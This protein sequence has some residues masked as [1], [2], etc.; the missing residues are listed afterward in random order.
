[1]AAERRLRVWFPAPISGRYASS[2]GSSYSLRKYLNSFP[3]LRV[4]RP[5]LW[6]GVAYTRNAALRREGKAEY[7][8]S[9]VVTLLGKS[10]PVSQGPQRMT[11]S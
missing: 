9:A 2:R 8:Q 10:C 1:M 11:H 7:T 3:F 6:P 5:V 4:K